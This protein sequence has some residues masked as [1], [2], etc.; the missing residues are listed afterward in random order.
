MALY[1]KLVY[2]DR[3]K[4]QNIMTIAKP[5]LTFL[6]NLI[7]ATIGLTIADFTNWMILIPILF[8]IGV[9]LVNINRPLKQKLGLTLVIIL[10][11]TA[12]LFVSILT[13]ISFDFDKYIFP[14]IVVGIAGV[15]ILGINGLLIKTIKLNFKTITLTF[16]LSGL[17]LPIWVLFTENIF[18]KTFSEIEIVR[19]DGVMLFWM[20][21]TTIGICL[22]IKKELTVSTINK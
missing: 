22:S 3:F 6:T 10:T 1:Y 18:P 7:L 11:S 12:I 5:Y 21:M 15:L 16:L 20:T 2:C 17:S 13:V 19:Q 14:G 9:P 8:G 4:T